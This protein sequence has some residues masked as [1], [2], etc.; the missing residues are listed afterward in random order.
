MKKILLLV[1]VAMAITVLNFHEVN[2]QNKKSDQEK[3]A[4]KKEIQASL[5][6]DTTFNAYVQAASNSANALKERASAMQKL[7]TE[8]MKLDSLISTSASSSKIEVQKKYVLNAEKNVEFAK[9]ASDAA[10]EKLDV[11]TKAYEAKHK[12]K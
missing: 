9:K 10:F 6:A 4:L 5:D 11:A 8:R 12:K 1:V 7:S 3:E 2:A